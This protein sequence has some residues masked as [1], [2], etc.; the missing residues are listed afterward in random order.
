MTDRLRI[1]VS[2]TVA[3]VPGQGGAAW[4]VAQWVLGLRRLGHDAVL[5]EQVPA[6]RF[7]ATAPR[8]TR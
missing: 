8:F 3:A 5:I 1:V 2:G 4:A 6:D 7:A